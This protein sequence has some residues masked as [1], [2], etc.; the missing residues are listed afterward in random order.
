MTGGRGGARHSRA[1]RGRRLVGIA[2]SGTRDP[3]LTIDE[4][5]AFARESSVRHEYV[6]GQAHAMTGGTR[7]HNRIG[8]NVAT[9]LLSAARGGP[10]RVYVSDVMVRAPGDVVYFPDVVVAC[11]PPGSDPH[12]EEAPCVVVEVLSPST[13][14]VDRREKALVDKTIPGLRAY[15]VVHQDMR[16]IERHWLDADGSGYH[17]D[18]AFEGAIVPIPCPAVTLTLDE[19]YDGVEAEGAE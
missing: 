3:L 13:A 5:L 15:V 17:A 16:R 11:G 12:V 10:C 2:N 7:R 4:F 14:S 18:A 8:L 9:R 19:I 6:G 1:P